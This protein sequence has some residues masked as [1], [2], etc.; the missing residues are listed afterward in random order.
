MMNEDWRMSEKNHVNEE[1]VLPVHL[2]ATLPLHLVQRSYNERALCL[3]LPRGSYLSERKNF[4]ETCR[5][6]VFTRGMLEG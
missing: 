2:R 1:Y 4:I 3:L 6:M 5:L